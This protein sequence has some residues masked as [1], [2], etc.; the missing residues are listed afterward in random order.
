[1]SVLENEACRIRIVRIPTL[2]SPSKALLNHP[3]WLHK[4]ILWTLV[5]RCPKRTVKSESTEESK[6][7][8][9]KLDNK[10]Q[11]MS[12]LNAPFKPL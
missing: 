5:V 2:N 1:M 4:T 3:D 6:N 12:R 11:I 8:G 10:T 7:L 9:E